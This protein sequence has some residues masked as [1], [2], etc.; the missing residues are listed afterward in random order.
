MGQFA[1][2]ML[3]LACFGQ[4]HGTCPR[5]RG[6]GPLRLAD[7]ISILLGLVLF[8]VVPASA[9][10]LRD[11]IAFEPVEDL[12]KAVRS[13]GD[14]AR[15]ALTFHQATLACSKC[16]SVDGSARS[17]G[18]DLSK[19]GR[20][21]SIEQLIESV[22]NPS[23]VIKPGF[24]PVT[25]QTADGRTITGLL[26][27]ETPETIVVREATL[28]AARITILKADIEDRQTSKVSLMPADVANQLANRQQFL[29]L[30]R[31]NCSPPPRCSSPSC[32]TM[33][34]RSTMQA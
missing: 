6:H 5:K 7:R 21:V 18:P 31:G 24:A 12:A 33:R 8:G 32:L 26:V 9:Q 17:I 22:L 25:V 19:L 3:T 16:H 10:T 30:L 27:E 14:A 15:G 2:A 28:E 13:G 20:E 29:D 23:K 11:S 34:V 1:G 4:V